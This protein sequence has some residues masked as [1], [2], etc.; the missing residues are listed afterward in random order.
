GQ[1]SPRR[2][3]TGDGTRDNMR[4]AAGG[5]ARRPSRTVER[6]SE[7]RSIAPGTDREGKG[8]SVVDSDS[9]ARGSKEGLRA[10]NSWS[11]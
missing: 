1:D 9:A 3:A 4:A 10:R 7:A 6:G 11:R 2:L 8:G 5:C